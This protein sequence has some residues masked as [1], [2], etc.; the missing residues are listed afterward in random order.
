MRLG[1]CH[2]R[3]EA[4][5]TPLVADA[6]GVLREDRSRPPLLVP[7][8]LLPSVALVNMTS[9]VVQDYVL[10]T[11]IHSMKNK[12]II[13]QADRRM[14]TRFAFLTLKVIY[15]MINGTKRDRA[16]SQAGAESGMKIWRAE[17]AK[18]KK[19]RTKFKKGIDAVMAAHKLGLKS[20]TQSPV[21]DRWD[22]RTLNLDRSIGE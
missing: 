19:L 2:E 12:R 20:A 9:D 1:P 14:K 3:C 17:Q 5:L 11:S 13:E 6:A 21:V 10:V 18:K 16:R 15:M 7:L 4:V 8:T 22:L